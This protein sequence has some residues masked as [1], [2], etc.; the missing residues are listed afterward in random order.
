MNDGDTG[1]RIETPPLLADDGLRALYD[2]WRELGQRDGGLP[3]LQ[4]FE[5]LHLPRLLPNIWIIEVEPESRRFRMRLAGENINAIYR[6]NIGGK[7]FADVFDPADLP[8]IIDRYSRALTE[9]AIFYAT[10]FVYAAAGR[11][12]AGER[13]G[14]PMLGRD[15]GT[16]ILLGATVYGGRVDEGTVLRPAGDVPQF[17]PVRAA[18]HVPVEIFRT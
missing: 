14:L 5:P 16:N 1:L 7:Y 10:G 15:G 8:T 6:R 4:S 2:Y 9:P 11:H 18:N 3:K 12:F 13:L 17:L